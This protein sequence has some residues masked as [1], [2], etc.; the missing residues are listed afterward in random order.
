MVADMEGDKVADMASNKKRKKS[1]FLFLADMLLHMVA[2]ILADMPADIF[3]LFLDDME[4]D[5]ISKSVH[6]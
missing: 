1:I 6:L 5:M 4:L 3:C 2:G